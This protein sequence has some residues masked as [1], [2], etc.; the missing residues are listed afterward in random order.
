[1]ASQDN[2]SDVTQEFPKRLAQETPKKFTPKPRKPCMDARAYKKLFVRREVQVF[3]NQDDQETQRVIQIIKR[4]S[5]GD[6]QEEV[7][8]NF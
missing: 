3:K 7:G 5:V 6:L 1:M 8:Q 2:A 4:P